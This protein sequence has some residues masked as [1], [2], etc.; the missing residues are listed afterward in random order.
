MIICKVWPMGDINKRPLKVALHGMDSRATKI[1]AMYFQVLCNGAALLVQ[2]RENADVDMFD[3]DVL[4]SKKILETYLQEQLIR[5]L[6]VL[7]LQ[8]IAQ[9]GVL[10]IKK[11][12][13]VDDMLRVI[14]DAKKL[15]SKATKKSLI[16]QKVETAKQKEEPENKRQDM[17]E[18]GIDQAEL[19]SSDESSGDS[20]NTAHTTEMQVAVDNVIELSNYTKKGSQQSPMPSF[21]ETVAQ[22][23][24]V[25]QKAIKSASKKDINNDAAK[26][27]LATSEGQGKRPNKSEADELDK[28]WFDDW[29]ETEI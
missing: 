27:E 5:P 29:L 10:Y 16:Y 9:N 7:S 8:D 3:S 15:I 28:D 6:I 11:P 22:R 25:K 4:A 12:V 14:A 2:D 26:N 24:G 17:L 23:Q 20:T 1:M 19:F 13:N 18:F 21:V